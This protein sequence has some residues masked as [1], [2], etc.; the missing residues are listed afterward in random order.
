MWNAK[1]YKYTHNEYFFVY[2]DE[3][4]ILKGEINQGLLAL[5]L[6][7]KI[8]STFLTYTFITETDS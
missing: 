7:L 6:P 8:R 2:I 4:I 5:L 3:K 1:I